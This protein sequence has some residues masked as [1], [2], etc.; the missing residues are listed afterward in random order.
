MD[1]ITQLN[2]VKL[3]SEQQLSVVGMGGTNSYRETKNP[4]GPGIEPGTLAPLVRFSA[5]ELSWP[6]TTVHL[7]QTTVLYSYYWI[8]LIWQVNQLLVLTY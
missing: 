7:A 4:V 8:S 1:H 3:F 5:T 2:C 6:I